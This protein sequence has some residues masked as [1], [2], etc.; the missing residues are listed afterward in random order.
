MTI[1]YYLVKEE[2]FGSNKSFVSEITYTTL[3]EKEN[4]NIKEIG[5]ALSKHNACE[6][7]EYEQPVLEELSK[8]LGCTIE[9]KLPATG[10]RHTCNSTCQHVNK[11]EENNGQD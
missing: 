5:Y 6:W 1:K 4:I 2:N 11:T 10:L 9:Q 7:F 8:L 3:G